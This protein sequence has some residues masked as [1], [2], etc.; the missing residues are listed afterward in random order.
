MISII[1]S[2]SLFFK[3]LSLSLQVSLFSKISCINYFHVV[4]LLVLSRKSTKLNY[5][6]IIWTIP[7]KQLDFSLPKACFVNETREQYGRQKLLYCIC[8]FTQPLQTNNYFIL[9]DT[10]PDFGCFGTLVRFF[11]SIW[12]SFLPFRN[13]KI[14][15][16]F[17]HFSQISI[18]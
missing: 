4:S 7:R 6:I 10:K 5:F 15:K 18:M 14:L 3:V 1:N 13:Y 9:M 17:A 8:G 16:I 11:M 2:V 12:R